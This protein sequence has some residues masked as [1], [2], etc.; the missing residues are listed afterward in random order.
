MN[1]QASVNLH[2]EELVLH[3]FSPG[4]RHGISEAVQAELARLL[5]Q[6]GA[7]PKFK[8]NRQVDSIDAGTFRLR[9]GPNP[10]SAGTE[11]ARAVHQGLNA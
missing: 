3:G 2:I 10:N 5:A 7:P 9:P 11:I 4:D 6:H 1:S 8:W